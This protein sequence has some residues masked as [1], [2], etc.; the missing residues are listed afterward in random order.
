MNCVEFV[1]YLIL[2]NMY[3]QEEF[4]PKKGLRQ[5]NPLPPYLFLMCAKGL[6]SQINKEEFL[7]NLKGFSINKFCPSLTYHFFFG[8]DNLLFFK[9]SAGDCRKIKKVLE[10]YEE[11][12]DRP[13]ISR[14]LPL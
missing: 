13:S 9:A 8:D 10:I 11:N 12:Q 3:L 1:K 7:S 14:N 5:G 2:I 4:I 6:L